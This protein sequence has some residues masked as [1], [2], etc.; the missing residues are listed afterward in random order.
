MQVDFTPSCGTWKINNKIQIKNVHMFLWTFDVS[1]VI[2][3]LKGPPGMTC[4]VKGLFQ[5]IWVII[6]YAIC[7][8]FFENKSETKNGVGGEFIITKGK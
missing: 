6:C 2:V 8:N 5:N 3:L 7:Y 1:L 4:C